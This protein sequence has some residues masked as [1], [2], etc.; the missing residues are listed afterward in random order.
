MAGGQR[1]APA[2]FRVADYVSFFVIITIIV[3]T[4]PII[5][6]YFGI[7][8]TDDRKTLLNIKTFKKCLQFRFIELNIIFM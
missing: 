3:I 1:S 4:K 6:Y 5:L 2:T 7:L 8:F